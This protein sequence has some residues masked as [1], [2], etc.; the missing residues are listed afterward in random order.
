MT[1][2]DQEGKFGALGHG[3]SDTDTGEL[4]DVE[5]GELYEAQIVSVVKGTKGT[6]GELSWST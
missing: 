5:G 4:L 2:V 6:P 3:I 1:Y